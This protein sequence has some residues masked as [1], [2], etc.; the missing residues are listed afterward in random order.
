MKFDAKYNPLFGSTSISDLFFTDYLP[1]LPPD[2]VKL[3]IYCVYLAQRGETPSKEALASVLEVTPPA[4]DESLIA[5]EYAGLIVRMQ[6]RIVLQDINQ[7]ELE[8]CYRHKTSAPVGDEFT[9]GRGVIKKR[10]DVIKS[11]SDRFFSG[12]MPPTWYTQIDLWFD[13]YKFE[14]EVM[15]LLFQ[16][17]AQNH[18]LTKPYVGKVA[19]NWGKHE[20]KT[21]EQLEQYLE[22]YDRYKNMRG[23]VVKKLRLNRNLY[24]YEESVVEK[25]FYTYHY[26]FDI[27]EIALKKSVSKANATLATFD[28]ILTDWFKNGLREKEEILAYEE[29]RKKKYLERKKQP[30]TS[31]ASGPKQKNNYESRSYDDDFL[32]SLYKNDGGEG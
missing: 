16:H 28:M 13:N 8:K 10:I 31:S 3:Y 22:E 20:I 26:T 2:C 5:L 25:W 7:I 19:E 21:P 32:N 4:V 27:V 12:Q 30:E 24:E 9:E 18:V 6:D 11:I 23:L 1:A 15:F 29:G 14:P 17:C